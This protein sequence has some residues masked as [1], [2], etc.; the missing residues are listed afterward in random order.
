[1]SI[2]CE[3]NS[4]SLSNGAQNISSSTD[5]TLNE[6]NQLDLTDWTFTTENNK[7]QIASNEFSS[8]LNFVS[9]KLNSHDTE[10]IVDKLR[11]IMRQLIL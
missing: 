3:K 6:F 9:S 1:M 10:S 11:K 7:S 8:Q 5:L 4:I 2:I